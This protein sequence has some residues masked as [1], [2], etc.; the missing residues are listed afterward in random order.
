MSYAPESSLSPRKAIAIGVVIALHAG[1]ILALQN[2]LARRVFD[3][4][5]DPLSVEIIKED[6]VVDRTPPPAPPVPIEIPQ[7][8]VPPPDIRIELPK[9]NN[10]IQAV[11]S[12]QAALAPPS[13]PAP[14]PVS[15][16]KKVVR[17]KMGKN[18]P[19]SEDFYPPAAKRIGQQGV[20]TIEVCVGPRGRMIGDPKLVQSSGFKSLDEG[21]VQLARK[22]TYIE[23]TVDGVPQPDCIQFTV[24]FQM[25]GGGW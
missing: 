2:G 3:I 4:K 17:A 21:A 14:G 6:V 10:A 13:P 11:S 1:L 9:V 25:S 12:V 19:N 8:Y 20:S 16:P 7:T 24:R 15:A 5:K 22:G 18:F 23:G